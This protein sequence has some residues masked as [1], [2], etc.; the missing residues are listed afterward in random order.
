MSPAKNKSKS[1]PKTHPQNHHHQK[2]EIIFPHLHNDILASLNGSITSAPYFKHITGSNA[3]HHS[4]EYKTNIMATFLCTNTS[5]K[6]R[7]WGSKKVAIRILGYRPG[8]GYNAV[9][10]NQRCKTCER[11]GSITID[12]KSYIERVTYRLKRWAGVE[13]EKPVFVRKQGP[14]HERDL[15]EGCK[16]GVCS[17]GMGG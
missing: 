1:T 8:N 15:C 17:W 5:C 12:K 2:A 3:A 4:N 6:Q 10:Y 13:V 11:L 7:G 14:E 9:V 16:R